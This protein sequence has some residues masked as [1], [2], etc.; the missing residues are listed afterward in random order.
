MKAA[1]DKAAAEKRAAE[2][3]AAKK[4]TNAKSDDRRGV[5]KPVPPPKSKK[6]SKGTKRSKGAKGTR[7]PKD[8][9]KI[10]GGVGPALEKKLNA[11]GVRTYAQLAKMDRKA[12]SD[13]AESV[14]APRDLPQKRGWKSTL[15]GQSVS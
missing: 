8:D 4:S 10:L 13:L 9:L 11:K 3:E 12:L 2:K 1:A 5:L 15:R 14:G 6:S 7:A